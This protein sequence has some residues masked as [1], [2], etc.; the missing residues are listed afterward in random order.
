[1]NNH[2][3]LAFLVLK[4]QGVARYNIKLINVSPQSSGNKLSVCKECPTVNTKFLI[5]RKSLL[6]L[7]YIIFLLNNRKY[8]ILLILQDIHYSIK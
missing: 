3:F 2:P 1:M 6:L 7:F 5:Y 8:I 4:H